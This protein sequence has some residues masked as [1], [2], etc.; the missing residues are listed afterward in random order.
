M[1]ENSGLTMGLLQYRPDLSI[2]VVLQQQIN[3]IN[4]KAGE[5]IQKGTVID[6]VLGIGLSN[7]R[8]PVPYLIG[9]NLEDARNRILGASLNLGIYIYDNTVIN[10]Q[11]STNAFVYRQNPSYYERSGL[12]L[13]SAIYLW[14]TT[15][16]TKLPAR[17]DMYIFTDTIPEPETIPIRW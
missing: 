12:Q 11:D 4:I 15:D 10:Y 1:I 5:S 17:S 16:S 14:L 6:L 3:G 2:D 7:Q 8:T 13:G 9:Y